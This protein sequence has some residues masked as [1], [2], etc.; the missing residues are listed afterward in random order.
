MAVDG[1]REGSNICWQSEQQSFLL[2]PSETEV[3]ACGYVGEDLHD[4][5]LLLFY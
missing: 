3:W 2:L 5:F 4:V 1:A